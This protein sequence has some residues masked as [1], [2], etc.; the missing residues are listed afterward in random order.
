MLWFTQER[1]WKKKERSIAPQPSYFIAAK[2]NTIYECIHVDEPTTTETQRNEK[3]KSSKA[4]KWDFY[5]K[6][7]NHNDFTLSGIKKNK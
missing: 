7:S 4:L 5:M 3:D 2:S 6:K 1:K